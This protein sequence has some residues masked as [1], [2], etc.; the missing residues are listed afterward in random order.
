MHS[1]PRVRSSRGPIHVAALNGDLLVDGEVDS[2]IG[3]KL[4]LEAVARVPGISRI[5]DRLRVQPATPMGDGE[6]RSHVRDAL[7]EEVALASCTIR[8]R[9][10]R[11]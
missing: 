1:E 10:A 2:V 6:I 7:L 11:R 5:V 4:G 8:E 9:R 3:K